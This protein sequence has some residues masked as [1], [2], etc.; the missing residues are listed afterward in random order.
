MAPTFGSLV[1]AAHDNDGRLTYI[2]NVGTGF[3]MAARRSLRAR[4]VDSGNYPRY[5]LHAE[6]AQ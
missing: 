2:G 3:S 5:R 6:A 4:L 1:L